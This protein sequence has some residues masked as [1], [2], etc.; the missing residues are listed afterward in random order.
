MAGIPNRD[1]VRVGRSRIQGQGVFAKRNI[2][3]GA[4]IIEY[5]GERVPIARLFAESNGGSAAHVYLFHLRED[6]AVDGARNGN[7]SRFI[8][9]SCDPN[10]EAYIFDDRIWIYAMR[11]IARHEELTFDYQLGPAFPGGRKKP[12]AEDYRCRCGSPNCRGTILPAG[13]RRG[14]RIAR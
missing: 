14:A 11:D 10:C 3:K 4:R 9:H 5:A 13:R 1:F 7:E 8:N 2:P 12:S 6:I